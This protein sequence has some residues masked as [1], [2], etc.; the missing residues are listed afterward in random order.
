MP[1]CIPNGAP[2][3]P[4]PIN[5]VKQ[6]ADGLP[7]ITLEPEHGTDGYQQRLPYTRV[8]TADIWEIN[9]WIRARQEARF[10][11]APWA[12]KHAHKE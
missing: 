5:A 12:L 9:S 3:P 8:E 7:L 11:S 6:A 2:P 10:K 1:V 4:L